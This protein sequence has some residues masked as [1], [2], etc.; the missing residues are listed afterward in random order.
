VASEIPTRKKEKYFSDVKFIKQTSVAV[1]LVAFPNTSPTML[2]IVTEI[3]RKK[4]SRGTPQTTQ[5]LRP[6]K[7]VHFQQF[8]VAMDESIAVSYG[9]KSEIFFP[10][11]Q[12]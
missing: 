11:N 12:I 10:I 5:K 4:R 6:K 8:S 7:A 2:K 1:P 9:L 3:H